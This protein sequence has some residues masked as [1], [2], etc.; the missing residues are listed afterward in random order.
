MLL[1]ALSFIFS[2]PSV[3]WSLAGHSGAV[4]DQEMEILSGKVQAA[5]E[6]IKQRGESPRANAAWKF[7][8]AC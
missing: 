7:S 3:F 8:S 1:T 6:G 4:R 2:L 5:R